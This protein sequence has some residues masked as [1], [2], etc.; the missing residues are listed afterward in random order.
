VSAGA[1]LPLIG[2]MLGHTQVQTTQRYAHLFDDP[3]RKAAETV[4][5]FM[6]QASPEKGIVD[7]AEQQ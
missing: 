2:Q 1:S 7:E 5:A 3:L 6:L 4:G